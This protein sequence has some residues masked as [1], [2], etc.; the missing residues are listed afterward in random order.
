MD[1]VAEAL[2]VPDRLIAMNVYKQS[3]CGHK[4]TLWDSLQLP[5]R[6]CLPFFFSTVGG[7]EVERVGTGGEMS[8]IGVHDEKVTKSQ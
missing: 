4:D 7:R 2:P 1:G 6:D 3:R 8:G 5:Q